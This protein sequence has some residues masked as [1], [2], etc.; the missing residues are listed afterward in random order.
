MRWRVTR[1]N[2]KNSPPRSSLGGERSIPTLLEQEKGGSMLAR[3]FDL[4][5]CLSSIS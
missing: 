1:A 3:H 5:S 4:L 2:Q